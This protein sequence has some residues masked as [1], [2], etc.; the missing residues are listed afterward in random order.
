MFYNTQ[1]T[2]D[3]GTMYSAGSSITSIS[4]SV[5]I[6]N[7]GGKTGAF[8]VSDCHI[9]DNQG[10]SSLSLQ[11]VVSNTVSFTNIPMS[12]HCNIVDEHDTDDNDNNEKSSIFHEF[13]I[14][15]PFSL[16]LIFTITLIYTHWT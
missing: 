4:D 10:S 3:I 15:Q 1:G 7:H 8:T 13:C 14:Y 12:I 11:V 16:A 9:G 6:G 2:S 5:F